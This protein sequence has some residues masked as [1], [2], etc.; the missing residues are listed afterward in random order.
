VERLG[1]HD[2]VRARRGERDF[3]RD[4]LNGDRCWGLAHQPGEHGGGRFHG[5]DPVAVIDE[6]GGELAGP[7]REFDDRRRLALRHLGM[8][9]AQRDLAVAIVGVGVARGIVGAFR[10]GHRLCRDVGV[11]RRGRAVGVFRRE[12]L[13]Q[14][15]VRRLGRITRPAPLVDVGHGS[16]RTAPRPPY[17]LFH[18]AAMLRE[19]A[20]SARFRVIR[21][22]RLAGSG[23]GGR[24][25][26]M[27]GAKGW[28]A[29]VCR[30]P[31]SGASHAD[32]APTVESAAASASP[33]VTRRATPLMSFQASLES[34][35]LKD[36]LDRRVGARAPRTSRV[37]QKV[38]ASTSDPTGHTSF[39]R[40]SP[41]RVKTFGQDLFG[42]LA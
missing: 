13:G 26:G 32:G 41:L 16:E 18:G 37:D 34:T 39:L 33:R 30:A 14:E 25:V 42:F 6:G 22:A 15:P 28:V 4:R 35:A 17:R 24:P 3:L 10:V 27:S 36:G 38:C 23:A 19:D 21:S 1:D 40:R 5:D 8:G 29:A 2:R 9:A 11:G 31:K 12:V 7:R 20:G